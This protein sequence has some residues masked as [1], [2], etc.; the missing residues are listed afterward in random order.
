MKLG[1]LDFEDVKAKGLDEV[2][3]L[4]FSD[5]YAKKKASPTAKSASVPEEDKNL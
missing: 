4:L 2:Y 1:K 3:K 5:S